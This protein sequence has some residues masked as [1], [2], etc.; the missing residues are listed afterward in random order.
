[1]RSHSTRRSLHGCSRP[2][3][4]SHSTSRRRRDDVLL[5]K[6]RIVVAALVFACGCHVAEDA[7]RGSALGD[8]GVTA[9]GSFCSECAGDRPFR[10]VRSPRAARRRLRRP[11]KDR[12]RRNPL[13]S[14]NPRTRR[15]R[16][17]TWCGARMDSSWRCR[18]ATRSTYGTPSGFGISRPISSVRFAKR[19]SNP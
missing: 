1:M 4:Q 7:A 3:G 12:F 15:R 17:T 11:Q 6:A 10:S 14:L 13:S 18:R 2:E 8:P 9:I 16:R 19:T 5:P